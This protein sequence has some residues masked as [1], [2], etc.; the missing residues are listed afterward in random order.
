MTLKSPAS[1][2]MRPRRLFEQQIIT[3]QPNTVLLPTGTELTRD[4]IALINAEHFAYRTSLGNNKLAL[5]YVGRI[6]IFL[7]IGIAIWSYIFFCN[8]RIVRNP[9]RG[10]ALTTL[11]LLC[12]CLAVFFGRGYPQLMLAISTLPVLMAATVSGH[13]LRPAIRACDGWIRRPAHPPQPRPR[14]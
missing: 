9:M 12:Q 8:E 1:A 13:C 7:L 2:A 10:L 6:G 11:M 3:Y 4:D 14:R 5:F